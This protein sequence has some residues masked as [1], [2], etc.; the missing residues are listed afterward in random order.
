[1]RSRPLRAQFIQFLPESFRGEGEKTLRCCQPNISHVSSKRGKHSVQVRTAS[2]PGCDSMNCKGSTKIV[3]PRLVGHIAITLNTT[4]PPKNLKPFGQMG[5]GNMLPESIEEQITACL[6]FLVPQ[7][8]IAQDTGMRPS[9]IFRIRIEH[10][11]WSGRR[12][13]NPY[14]KTDKARRFVGMS[15][16]METLLSARCGKRCDGWLFPSD[17]SK[18]GHINSVAVGFRA[19][20]R[21][22]GVNEKI[23]PYS[24]R[25][26]YGTYALEATGNTFAVA[27]SMGHASLQSMKPY[28]HT[29]L[30]PVRDAIN[31]RNQETGS[32]HVSSHV[33]ENAGREAAAD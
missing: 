30:D 11:D 29:R 12:I 14:G 18:T 26:T 24:A 4:R 27:D 16:R 15:E 33:A 22:T 9:E 1:M 2:N 19:L 13:W 21:R 7:R 31:R 25:H 17:H 5:L 8:H 10:I 20:R 28:Q 32:R 6:K 3:H 23:V